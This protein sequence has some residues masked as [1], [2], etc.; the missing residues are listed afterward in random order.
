MNEWN[1]VLFPMYTTTCMS[2]SILQTAVTI[3]M[4]YEGRL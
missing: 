3:L 1:E 4:W 2:L